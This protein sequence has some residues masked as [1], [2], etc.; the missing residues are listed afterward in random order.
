MTEPCVDAETLAAW[1]DKALS[2]EAAASVERHAASCARCQAMM[3]VFVRAELPAVAP[4]AESWWRR[5]R[6]EWLVPIGAAA[7]AVAIWVAVPDSPDRATVSLESSPGTGETATPRDDTR[8]PQVPPRDSPAASAVGRSREV[9]KADSTGPSD[10]RARQE[11]VAP[12]EKRELERDSA[13]LAK[14]EPAREA[15]QSLAPAATP[16]EALAARVQP[17]APA[18]ADRDAAVGSRTLG[19][20]RADTRAAVAVSQFAAPG[21]G[22]RWR[23]VDGRVERST[24]GATGWQA[25][26]AIDTPGIVAG[27][28]PDS[29]LCWVVGRAGAIWLTTDG[30]QWQR[31]PPPAPVDLVDITARGTRSADVTAADGRVFRT[32]DA[33]GTWQRRP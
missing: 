30:R 7:A 1:A 29:S 32:D 6:L 24:D 25:V 8:A 33:G 31:L 20:A 23:I 11:A 26:S 12:D 21:G 4:Q 19:A 16:T 2:P 10:A 9:A 5:L 13:A 14:T 18:G 15:A 17:A 28:A 27:S 22:V 3:A